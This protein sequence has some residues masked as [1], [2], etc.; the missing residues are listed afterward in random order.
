M[1][2][3]EGVK[4]QDIARELG[5]SLSMV[6]KYIAQAQQCCGGGEDYAQR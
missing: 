6:K 5:V 3:L 2:Q 4:Q 1:V